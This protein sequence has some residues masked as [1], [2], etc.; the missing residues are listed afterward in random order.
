VRRGR[1]LALS[2][3]PPP[4]PPPPLRRLRPVTF[5]SP[6]QAVYAIDESLPIRKAHK[7]PDI[8]ELYAT[9]LDGAPGVG[10]A[11]EWLHT[12]YRDRSRETMP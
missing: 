1:C 3:P 8:K 12:T 10:R 4:P 7:N 11:H 2:P 9:G 6:R 5:R